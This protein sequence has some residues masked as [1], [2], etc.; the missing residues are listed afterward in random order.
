MKFS[1]LDLFGALAL[2]A[3]PLVGGC[4]RALDFTGPV[5]VQSYLRADAETTQAAGRGTVIRGHVYNSSDQ[6]ARNVRLL[7]EGLDSADRTVSRRVA[8]VNGDVG[9]MNR[10]YFEIVAPGPGAT[11]RV[12]VLFYDWVPRDGPN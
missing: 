12:S 9:Y 5:P 7:V 2:G 6:A 3:L 10:R 1:R 11:F 8:W 4:A